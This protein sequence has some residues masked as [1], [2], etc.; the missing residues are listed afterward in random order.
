MLALPEVRM[1]RETEEIG[2]QSAMLKQQYKSLYVVLRFSQTTRS[3][4]QKISRWQLSFGG[5]HQCELFCHKQLYWTEVPL[6][7]EI[8]SLQ[9]Q[10][11]SDGEQWQNHSK[12][13]VPKLEHN[14][15]GGLTR[16][17][18]PPGKHS[19][20]Y[21]H[22]RLK[23][24]WCWQRLHVHVVMLVRWILNFAQINIKTQGPKTC[25]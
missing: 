25:I 4:R 23:A 17:M 9:A 5:K 22:L 12:D 24:L 14:L 2:W 19:V 7:S 13:R 20:L 16:A 11:E 10:T 15:H 21:L 6:S 3:F 18:K 1:M 8:T